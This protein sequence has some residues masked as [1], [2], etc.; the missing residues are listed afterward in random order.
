MQILKFYDLVELNT[1]K[2]IYKV[3]NN[4][5]PNTIQTLFESRDRHYELRGTEMIRKPTVRTNTKINCISVKGVHLWNS[6]TDE[7]KLSTSFLQ[8]K[9][10]YKKSAIQRYMTEI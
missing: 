10:L 8:L 7:L 5:V 3:K 2:F 9:T 1:I 6:S 4:L